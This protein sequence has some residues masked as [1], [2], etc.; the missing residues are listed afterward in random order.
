MH[1]VIQEQQ[2]SKTNPLHRNRVNSTVNSANE[3]TIVSAQAR[4][5]ANNTTA[6]MPTNTQSL[7]NNTVQSKAQIQALGKLSTSHQVCT[8]HM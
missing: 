6:I 2:N 4:Q 1:V 3:G 8:H 5:Q 7:V